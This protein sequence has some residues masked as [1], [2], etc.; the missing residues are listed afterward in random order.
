MSPA[1]PPPLAYTPAE[2]LLSIV[3]DQ[4]ACRTA[5]IDRLRPR[6]GTFLAW[7]AIRRIGPPS[8]LRYSSGQERLGKQ[9]RKPGQNIVCYRRA[10]ESLPGDWNACGAQGPKHQ[11]GFQFSRIR[12][13]SRMIQ[14]EF[15]VEVLPP[16][17]RVGAH[18][19]R[20][21]RAAVVRK[22]PDANDVTGVRPPGV[23]TGN[24]TD[25][26]G[27]API[28]SWTDNRNC[29]NRPHVE[30]IAVHAYQQPA[31]AGDRCA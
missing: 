21:E 5:A 3:L 1:A 14:A 12:G 7:Y 26:G 13:R 29:L 19:G 8:E 10:C 22:T 20:S 23:R 24:S 15:K 25:L 6:R 30:K 17:G 28:L 11:G 2:A 4:P 18:T 9:M 31:C 16:V 27:A